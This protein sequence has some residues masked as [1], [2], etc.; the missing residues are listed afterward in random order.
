VSAQSVPCRNLLRSGTAKAKETSGAEGN[1]D[2]VGDA[3]I[4]A[5]KSD[6]YAFWK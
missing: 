3:V 4:F 1:K 2:P 5:Y 6:S